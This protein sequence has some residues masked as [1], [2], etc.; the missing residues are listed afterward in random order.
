MAQVTVRRVGKLTVDKQ[1]A[2]KAMA[3][4]ILKHVLSRIAEGRDARD[5]PLADYSPLY[6]AQL[7]AIGQD[8][9]PRARRTGALMQALRLARTVVTPNGVEM[10]FGVDDSSS[11]Q[12]PRPPPWVFSSKQT[13]A[14]QVSALARW[15]AAPKRSTTSPPH[16]QLLAWLLRGNGRSKPRALLGVSPRGRPPIIAALERAHIFRS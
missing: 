1:A 13:P 15:R 5:A 16:S 11:K 9:R 10:V 14:E 3:P 6:R 12:T 2:A 8:T 7:A 4:A